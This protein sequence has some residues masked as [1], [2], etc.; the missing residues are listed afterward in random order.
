MQFAINTAVQDSTGFSAAQLN[1][2]RDPKIAKG[3]YELIGNHN[4]RENTESPNEFCLRMKDSVFQAKYYNLRRRDWQPQVGELVY[5][6]D[7]PQSN[8][9]NA[10]AAKLAPTFSGPYRVF[11]Y[12][13]P[14]VVEL[15]SEDRANNT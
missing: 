1:F 2:G 10:F 5:K 7:F 15:K 14:T 6:R 8:A 9:N 12:I 11:N 3:V 4:I 13:S